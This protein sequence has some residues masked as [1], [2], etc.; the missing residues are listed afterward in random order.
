MLLHPLQ[1]YDQIEEPEIATTRAASLRALF[2]KRLVRE[3]A[4]RSEPIVGGDVH[5]AVLRCERLTGGIVDHV[6]AAKLA[7]A[8]MNV[9]DDGPERS[10]VGQRTMWSEHIEYKTLSLRGLETMACKG[11]QRMREY[12]RG[13]W[14]AGQHERIVPCSLAPGIRRL[15]SA[16]S[17]VLGI[18]DG[19]EAHHLVDSCAA[20]CSQR[21]VDDDVR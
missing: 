16:E 17:L 15:W 3:P 13:L 19:Q 1:R 14:A 2:E 9:E 8:T 7:R 5:Y 11:A 18:R 20:H 4:E 6:A 12:A 21:Q 10:I